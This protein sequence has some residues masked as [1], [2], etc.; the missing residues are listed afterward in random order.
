MVMTLRAFLKGCHGIESKMGHL[1]SHRVLLLLNLDEWE[2]KAREAKEG[3][4]GVA[5]RIPTSLLVGFPRDDCFKL[6]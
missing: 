6:E 4:T 2:G 5:L 1:Q 3:Y